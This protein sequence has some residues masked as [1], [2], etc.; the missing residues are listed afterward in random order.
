MLFT[1]PVTIDMVKVYI[2]MTTMMRA[3]D[4]W[5]RGVV[6]LQLSAVHSRRTTPGGVLRLTV[7]IPTDLGPLGVT[8][9]EVTRSTAAASGGPKFFIAAIDDGSF[10]AQY[11]M[12]LYIM[13]FSWSAS[14]MILCVGE[15]C[16]AEWA[17]FNRPAWHIII[18]L[19]CYYYKE[20]F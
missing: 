9:V 7:E 20:Y 12:Y 13:K 2:A 11:E 15:S 17:E 5:L 4:G 19:Y 6:L 10:A 16:S 14:L 8:V 18:I 3:V 1:L